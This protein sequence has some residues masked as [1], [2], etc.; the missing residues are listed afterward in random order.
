[1][2]KN[3]PKKITEK[4]ESWVLLEE[5]NSLWW[6]DETYSLL[7]FFCRGANSR[8]WKEILLYLN[9][10]IILSNYSHYTRLV[11]NYSQKI[12]ALHK[13]TCTHSLL[14]ESNMWPSSDP[15]ICFV[16][17]HLRRK[18]FKKQ[19]IYLLS[20]W[21]THLQIESSNVFLQLPIKLYPV[22]SPVQ[23]CTLW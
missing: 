15:S 17:L 23:L 9:E 21:R 18:T 13:H 19:H 22:N 16:Q 8:E 6:L 11:F 3:Y 4:G 7:G 12:S 14:K 5:Q 2:H 20:C 1:M 10:V